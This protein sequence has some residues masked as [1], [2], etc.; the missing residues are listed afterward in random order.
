MPLEHT[1]HIEFI[2]GKP[3]KIIRKTCDGLSQYTIDQLYKDDQHNRAKY[4]KATEKYVAMNTTTNPYAND[5]TNTTYYV[6]NKSA[7]SKNSEK[8]YES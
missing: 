1:S 3:G 4:I 7:H 8:L 2:N 5:V 6:K